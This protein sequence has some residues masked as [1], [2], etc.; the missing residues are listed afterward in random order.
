MKDKDKKQGHEDKLAYDVE[1]NQWMTELMSDVDGE[2]DQV[3]SQ[4]RE[5]Y[6]RMFAGLE[7]LDKEIEAAIEEGD[8]MKYQAATIKKSLVQSRL[9]ELEALKIF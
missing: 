4:L 7:K 8:E 5:S 2:L 6:S 9:R 1:D 3:T